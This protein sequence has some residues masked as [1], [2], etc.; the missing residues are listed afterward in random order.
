MGDTTLEK[1]VLTG[2]NYLDVSNPFETSFL[3]AYTS[4]TVTTHG[5]E[6]VQDSVLLHAVNNELMVSGAYFFSVIAHY[7]H[8][9]TSNLTFWLYNL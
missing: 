7:S 4:L 3:D 1:R 2:L 5:D 8:D 6:F 9:T